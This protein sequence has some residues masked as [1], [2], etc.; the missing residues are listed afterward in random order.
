MFA[1]RRI[2]FSYY[3]VKESMLNLVKWF[4]LVIKDRDFDDYFI[5]EALKF[6]IKNTSK[7]INKHKFYVGYE[8]DV[9]RMNLCVRLI[10]KIQSGYYETEYQEY[11]SFKDF[12]I[13]DNSEKYFI[14]YPNT[15][16]KVRNDKNFGNLISLILDMGTERHNKAKRILFRL[17]EYNIEKWWN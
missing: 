17:L 10:D 2:R 5:L 13:E 15:L 1:L 9:E 8:R 7:Y 11:C 14:K 3:D 12:T 6:K 4:K 16:R